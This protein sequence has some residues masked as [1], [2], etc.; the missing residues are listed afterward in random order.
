[1]NRN[2]RRAPRRR[3]NTSRTS[4]NKGKGTTDGALSPFKIRIK[5]KSVPVHNRCCYVRPD[6]T[7]FG[8]SFRT[9]AHSSVSPEKHRKRAPIPD[10]Q[11]VLEH[12]HRD[13][14]FQ[15]MF[16][17]QCDFGSTNPHLKGL[18]KV[19]CDH[20]TKID[21]NKDYV[22][23]MTGAAP[24]YVERANSSQWQ[25]VN[26]IDDID[27]LLTDD[28]RIPVKRDRFRKHI[29][30]SEVPRVKII[31]EKF[32]K[33]KKNNL[34]LRRLDEK[35]VC[36]EYDIFDQSASDNVLKPMQR[37]RAF[38][39]IKP[40]FDNDE[41]KDKEGD[42]LPRL[43]SNI[44]HKFDILDEDLK[45][46]TDKEIEIIDGKIEEN[47][48]YLEDLR[49]ILK[50]KQVINRKKNKTSLDLQSLYEMAKRDGLTPGCDYSEVNFLSK[51]E[52]QEVKDLILQRCTS[53][54]HGIR[55]KR[56]KRKKEKDSALDIGLISESIVAELLQDDAKLKVYQ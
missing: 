14:Q 10:N 55:R 25:N 46:L 52:L 30:I 32:S 15:T 43:P 33:F 24:A 5:E 19:V 53:S 31:A 37:M 27:N 13:E 3:E 29:F 23:Q 9:R 2:Q 7:D 51:A 34:E 16:E 22:H 44:K 56:V 49:R 48:T 8:Q 41:S 21:I 28:D 1:M 40:V 11:K 6:R 39:S 42:A 45:K 18:K 4:A 12:K 35:V 47:H 50:R 38:F 36:V 17:E 26:S 54:A 20:S